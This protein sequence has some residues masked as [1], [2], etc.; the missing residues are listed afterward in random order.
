MALLSV[1]VAFFRVHVEEEEIVSVI[2]TVS[3]LVGG[4]YGGG[5]GV[6]E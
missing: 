6:E 2:G 4:V 1:L 3:D 5:M